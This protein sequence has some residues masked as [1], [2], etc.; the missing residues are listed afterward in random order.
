MSEVKKLGKQK[1]H[2]FT[3]TV[4]LTLKYCIFR[5]RTTPAEEG[6]SFQKGEV[7]FRPRQH[8]L[9]ER[10]RDCAEFI[11]LSVPQSH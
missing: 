4:T 5:Y 11:R 2:N 3:M 10:G 7:L 9:H 1:I 6:K 8:G